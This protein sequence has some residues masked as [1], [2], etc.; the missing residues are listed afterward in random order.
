MV[1]TLTRRKSDGYTVES[2]SVALLERG[3]RDESALP[4]LWNLVVPYL[5]VDQGATPGHIFELDRE[6]TIIGRHPTCDIVVENAAVS[7]QHAAVAETHGEFHVEDLRSR[8][9]TFVNGCLLEGT[10]ALEDN[11][12]IQISDHL[13]RYR[14]AK[15]ATGDAADTDPNLNARGQIFSLDE[16][17]LDEG[18]THFE[19]SSVLGTLNLSDPQAVRRADPEQKLQAVLDI[20]RSL[21]NSLDLSELLASALDCLF[22]VFPEADH[23]FVLLTETDQHKIRVHAAKSRDGSEADPREHVS[24]TVVKRTLS[25]GDAVLSADV[26]DDTRFQKS[27]SIGELQLRSILCVPLTD[28]NGSTFGVVQLD[29]SQ[30]E[31]QFGSED[32]DTLAS[33]ASQI[34]LAVQNARLHKEM[35]TQRDMQRDLEFA[36]QVQLGFLPS[37]RPNTDGYEFY[38]YYEAAKRVGGDYFDYILL[39]GNRIAVTIGDVAGKG[40]PAALLM[41]RLFSSARYHLLTK[42]TVESALTELNQEIAASRL[43]HRFITCL[44]AIVDQTANTITVASAGHPG[45]LIRSTGGQVESFPVKSRG[46]PIGIS[47]DQTFESVTRPLD[48]GDTFVIFTDGITEAMDPE[49]DLYGTDRLS[50]Y[51]SSGPESIADLIEGIVQDVDKFAKGQGQRDDMCLVGFRRIQ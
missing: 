42:P 26:A 4:S 19:S 13:F 5:V 28:P 50:A 29:T 44:F 32:L 38:D 23:G 48:V 35:L 49:N 11:D 30:I 16:D 40:M 3:G 9:K 8:N 22:R 37:T 6:T 41:A 7:R 14:V 21:G 43:G 20:G 45:S 17:T 51:I 12:L 46:L 24:M 31:R 27:E 1:D 34:G 33:V 47:L 10:A 36:M 2:A 25:T 39:P 18:P 15:P